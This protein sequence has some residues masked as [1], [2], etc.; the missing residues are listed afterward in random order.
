MNEKGQGGCDCQALRII[1]SERNDRQAQVFQEVICTVC[2]CSRQ[3]RHGK[4]QGDYQ[5]PT[6]GL[7]SARSARNFPSFQSRVPTH[8]GSAQYPTGDQHP[9]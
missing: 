4:P 1:V 7:A 6:Q 9:N 3:V 5:A 8:A 2:F